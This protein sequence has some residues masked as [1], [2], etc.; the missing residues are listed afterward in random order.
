[1]MKNFIKSLVL[2]SM[3]GLSP[4]RADDVQEVKPSALQQ[5]I[6]NEINDVADVVTDAQGAV[7]A[8]SD[9][10]FPGCTGCQCLEYP[11]FSRIDQPFVIFKTY[12]KYPSV[13]ECTPAINEAKIMF[14]GT[15]NKECA[16]KAKDLENLC[17]LRKKIVNADAGT[18]IDR[19]Y[20]RETVMG[21]TLAGSFNLLGLLSNDPY[22]GNVLINE[23]SKG[24]PMKWVVRDCADLRALQVYFKAHTLPK[25]EKPLLM[26]VVINGEKVVGDDLAFVNEYFELLDGSNAV[27]I[28]FFEKSQKTFVNISKTAKEAKYV[29]ETFGDMVLREVESEF[30]DFD[31]KKL[32]VLATKT[33]I[34]TFTLALTYKLFDELLFKPVFDATKE[35]I[36]ETFVKK[37]K[38]A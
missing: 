2:L 34:V 7:N 15:G 10:F 22:E 5:D 28:E 37:A 20:V 36:K 32:T 11:E 29:L 35:K 19:K 14:C 12:G 24:L 1:M 27:A 31:V 23:Y 6:L 33:V 16:K 3:L 18:Q 8:Q 17:V 21:S 13:I 9:M 26:L 30:K 4:L 38:T 25:Q